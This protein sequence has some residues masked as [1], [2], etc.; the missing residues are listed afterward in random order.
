M[1]RVVPSQIVTLIAQ[2]FPQVLEQREHNNAMNF[3]LDK[4]P[5][6]TAILRLLAQVPPELIVLEGPRYTEFEYAIA[7][8]DAALK[9]WSS[10]QDW[11]LQSV[12]QFRNLSPIRLIY[13]GLRLCPD[14]FPTPATADLAFITDAGFRENLRL[15]LSA[16]NADL[17]NGEW[18][19]ATVLAGSLC[20]ALLLWALQQQP[21]EA[22][23]AAVAAL[24]PNPI[25]RRPAANLED[26]GLHEY[27]EVAASLR[28]ISTDTAAQVRLAKNYRNLIHPGRAIREGQ[29]CNRGTALAAA[30]AV[31]LIVTDLS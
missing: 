7:A 8:V 31:H 1:S 21:P 27:I 20:E 6:C 25:N 28:L 10:H 24:V 14:E 12:P 30:A 22:V 11:L 19:G 23:I 29:V 4:M 3:G 2:F 16:V 13:D 26:W 18:K 9:H 17:V 5:H 15:D